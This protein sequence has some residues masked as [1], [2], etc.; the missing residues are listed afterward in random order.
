M[1]Q[2]HKKRCN[3]LLNIHKL[4]SNKMCKIYYIYTHNHTH[5]YT[6]TLAPEGKLMKTLL[7]K[8]FGSFITEVPMTVLMEMFVIFLI[9]IQISIYLIN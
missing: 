7:N 4:C 3:F 9:F 2:K 6:H 5:I 1:A 8:P